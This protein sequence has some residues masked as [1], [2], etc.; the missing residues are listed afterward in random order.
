MNKATIITT[1]E[2]DVRYAGDW[3]S[4]ITVLHPLAM[5]TIT[6]FAFLTLGLMAHL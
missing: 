5:L 1:A 6:A 2:G 4:K 3:L